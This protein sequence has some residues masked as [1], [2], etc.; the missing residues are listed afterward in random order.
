ASVATSDIS[1]AAGLGRLLRPTPEIDRIVAGMG[2][3]NSLVR[4]IDR[5]Q[6]VLLS[7]GDIGSATGLTLVDPPQQQEGL[8]SRL[9]RNVLHRLYALVLAEPDGNYM[10]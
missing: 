5:T 7:S 6:R 9:R 10:D 8:L 1:E 2:H 4:V 3:A